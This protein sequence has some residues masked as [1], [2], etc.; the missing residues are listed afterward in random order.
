[1]ITNEEE[2]EEE[3]KQMRENLTKLRDIVKWDIQRG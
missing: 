1:M 2:E 3:E